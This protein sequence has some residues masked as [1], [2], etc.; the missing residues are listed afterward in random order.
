M[1]F[2]STNNLIKTPTQLDSETITFLQ[3]LINKH[4]VML[5]KCA[6]HIP[7]KTSI[8]RHQTPPLSRT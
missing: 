6:H 2:I 8:H 7:S 1:T 3:V 5:Y 4:M